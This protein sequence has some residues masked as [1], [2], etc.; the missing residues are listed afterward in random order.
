MKYIEKDKLPNNLN[1]NNKVAI[2][3]PDKDIV[4]NS[5]K[6]RPAYIVYDN[7]E[8]ILKWNRSLRFSLAVCTLKDKFKDEL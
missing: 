6:L 8:V 7:Y 5:E 4:K 1:F 3:T 2:V